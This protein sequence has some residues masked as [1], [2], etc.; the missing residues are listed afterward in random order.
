MRK[1]LYIFYIIFQKL[2]PVALEESFQILSNTG[3]KGV[4]LTSFTSDLYIIS[5]S[6]RYNIIN[7]NFN[8]IKDNKN[9]A[10]TNFE[11]SNNFEIVESSINK[12]KNESIILIGE[13]RGNTINLY[14]FNITA[15]INDNN[16]K[17][18]D[19]TNSAVENS[20][21]SLIKIG[22]DKYLLSYILT[23]NKFEN[24]V[25]KYSSY[26]GGYRLL[27]KFQNNGDVYN[28]ISCFLLYEQV[29][30]CYYSEK[31]ITL[32]DTVKCYQKII[33]LD[34][35][36]NNNYN[37]VNIIEFNENNNCLYNKAVYLS[38]DYAVFCYMV[39]DDNTLYYVIKKLAIEF[40]QFNLTIENSLDIG[41]INNC[42]SNINKMDLIKVE[43]NKFLIGCVKMPDDDQIYI[44]LIT[45]DNNYNYLERKNFVFNQ[46]VKSTLTLFTHTL[47]YSNNN[48]GIIFNDNN[49]KLK[50]GYLDLTKCFKLNTEILQLRFPEEGE[51]II[52]DFTLLEYLDISTENENE[53]GNIALEE[54][55]IVSFKSKDNDK[56][57]FNYNILKDYAGTKTQLNIGDII[58]KTDQLIINPIIENEFSSG[59]FYIEVAPISNDREIQGRSCKFEF[60][61]VC[62]EGCSKCK[63]YD[64]EATETSKH[65]CISCKSDYYSLSDLCL[66]DCSLINGYHNLFKTKECIY[67]EPEYINDC[68]YKIW[69]IDPDMGEDSCIN[70]SFCP[71]DYP[72]V[73]TS[74]GE[75]IDSC[76]YSELI[77]GECYISNIF[78][79]GEDS[80]NM[81]ESEISLL[82]DNIFDYND[83][84]QID[85]SI[86]I[87]G[88]NITI[89][90]TD[91]LKIKNSKNFNQ[92]ISEFQLGEC[93]NSLKET[94]S[95][96]DDKELIILKIDLRRND[97]VSAQIE[98]VI[99]SPVT[100]TPPSPPLNDLSS[101]NNIIIYSPIFAN[102][103]YLY[104]IKELYDKGYD[105]FNIN[106]QFYSDLCFPLYDINFN[107]DLTLGKRQNIYY[108]KNA[109]LCEAKCKYIGFDIVKY[110]AICDCP[111]KQEINIDILNKNIFKSKENEQTIYY[112]QT[113][114]NLKTA[115]CIKTIFS[116]KGFKYNWGSYFMMLMIIGFIVFTI[117]WFKKGEDMILSYIR[118]ILDIILMGIDSIYKE[119]I[120]KNYEDLINKSKIKNKK[121]DILNESKESNNIEDNEDYY[122]NKENNINNDK[123]I[124]NSD[125]T[126]K[127]KE[128]E[129]VRKKGPK[130]NALLIRSI[131]LNKENKMPEE[132]LITEN[133]KINYNKNLSDIEKDLLSYDKAKIM[134][135]RNYYG[136]YW[137][138]IKY[139][140]LI[141]FTF[142][143]YDDYN[144]FIIKIISLF[145]LLSLN[146]LYNFIFFF[147]SIIDKIYDNK[148]KYSLKIQIL[149]VFICSVLFSLTILLC[150]FIITSHRKYIKL[151][152]FDNYERAKKESYSIYNNLIK[153]YIIFIS[154]E[155]FLLLMIWDFITGFCAIFYYT[156]NHLFLNAF[157]SF[158]FSMIYP[159]IYCLL[160]TL[161]RHLGLKKNKKNYYCFSQYI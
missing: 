117:I 48:Y 103:S 114:S 127:D 87:Y 156:Q 136:Y 47:S 137:S 45:V 71:L 5:S 125:N 6:K 96:P 66:K 54:Y 132:K 18:L 32:P 122:N 53:N 40:S 33:A 115:K 20:K 22:N 155:G 49:N 9:S 90:I 124:I 72:Y 27:G 36:L 135:N 83:E 98:Y 12:N 110:K 152:E 144:F 134:D 57:V 113:V 23:G 150:R 4:A 31:R 105:I 143:S 81:I 133:K 37:R 111:I 145:L 55:I 158:L 146:L 88:N 95:I 89:E 106:E 60:D 1:I 29:P 74:S 91:S 102:E 28:Y 120:K 126:L 75:C 138:L 92:L 70:S 142:F 8:L 58:T 67:E 157:F 97:T 78:G 121:K 159:F 56:N 104:K 11:F 10:N 34:I 41:S 38:D 42:N 25:F 50:Y 52:N 99:F 64:S 73:Y 69:Y 80:I 26:Q 116:N 51:V 76:R 77:S 153:R 154:V 24:K 161:F 84:N 43:D 123:D 14:S 59:K 147:D 44:D 17:L 21:I 130:K 79:G 7:K 46:N 39:D 131:K 63:S 118:E 62:Y 86:V 13:N 151:K 94:N 101:C 61:T 128:N 35:V 19:R 15:P 3:Q 16:P 112:K 85:K 65:K 148:G 68:S 100:T 119:K 129:I 160:P 149:N 107:A 139:R 2:I 140:H 141:L 30:I 109:N 93:E 108:Y 82:G